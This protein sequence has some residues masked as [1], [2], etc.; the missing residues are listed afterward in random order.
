[1]G[2]VPTTPRLTG[3]ERSAPGAV[4]PSPGPVQRNFPK[5]IALTA[6]NAEHSFFHHEGLDESTWR[7][8]VLRLPNLPAYSRRAI[9]VPIVRAVPLARDRDR[10]QACLALRVLPALERARPP[11][12]ARQRRAAAPGEHRSRRPPTRRRR[13]QVRP[14]P[15]PPDPTFPLPTSHPISPGNPR[16]FGRL[17]MARGEGRDGRWGGTGERD[18]RWGRGGRGRVG[19]GGGAGTGGADGLGSGGCRRPAGADRGRRP[20]VCVPARPRRAGSRALLLRQPRH[21]HLLAPGPAAS[22]RARAGALR[23]RGLPCRAAGAG[24]TGALRRRAQPLRMLNQVM[25]ASAPSATIGSTASATT[26]VMASSRSRTAGS[27]PL[28]T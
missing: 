1:M 10:L 20:A 24:R 17:Q 8:T 22:L 13:P 27:G 6:G 25:A 15:D 7:H 9:P 21:P 4:G 12:P 5:T 18:R 11:P 16:P 26:S 23:P 2:K 28:S 19:A 14:L 3:H